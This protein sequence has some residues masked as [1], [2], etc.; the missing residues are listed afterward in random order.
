MVFTFPPSVNNELKNNESKNI[1]S[2]NEENSNLK[3]IIVDLN[4]KLKCST[5]YNVIKKLQ[6][7]YETIINHRSALH[8]QLDDYVKTIDYQNKEINMLINQRDAAY[9]EITFYKKHIKL[10][11]SDK[12]DLQN[13]FDFHYNSTVEEYVE[14]IN[15]MSQQIKTLKSENNNLHF[16]NA[17]NKN[18]QK[19]YNTLKDELETTVFELDEKKIDNQEQKVMIS[20][21]QIHNNAIQTKLNDTI[22]KNIDLKVENDSISEKY[23]NIANECFEMDKFIQLQDKTLSEQKKTNDKLIESQTK[24]EEELQFKLEE[25]ELQDKLEKLKEEQELQFNLEKLE[26]EQELEYENQQLEQFNSNLN[27]TVINEEFCIIDINHE[28]NN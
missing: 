16:E 22:D 3:K 23:N 26:Q 7:D 21:L 1:N 5:N 6:K 25:E 28:L 9:K 15:S 14:K 10:L 13:D 17:A 18:Y 8:K 19:L 12:K 27:N 20:N 11:K 24:I 4:N 2:L